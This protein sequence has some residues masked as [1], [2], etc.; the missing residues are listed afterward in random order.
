MFAVMLRFVYT[1]SL[2]AGERFEEVRVPHKGNIQHDFI[3]G[4]YTVAEDFLRLID[5]SATMKEIQLGEDERR[6]LAEASLVARYGEKQSPIRPEQIL[7]PRRR[8]DAKQLPLDDH[9]PIQENM[10]RGQPARV[11][12]RRRGPNQPP[13]DPPNQRHRPERDGLPVRKWRASV[14]MN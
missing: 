11:E 9:N 8:G 6:V 7:E 12:A 5:A 3:E 10:I 1:N 13:P 2:V 4:V 14:R